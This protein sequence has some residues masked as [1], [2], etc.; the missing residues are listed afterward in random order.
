MKLW[1]FIRYKVNIEL[2]GGESR[3]LDRACMHA[4]IN[5]VSNFDWYERFIAKIVHDKKRIFIP[6]VYWVS[7]FQFGIWDENGIRMLSQYVSLNCISSA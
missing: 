1:T 3:E 2:G 6:W 4:C 5:F 7:Y